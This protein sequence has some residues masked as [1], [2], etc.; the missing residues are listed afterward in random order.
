MQRAVQRF[1]EFE[2]LLDANPEVSKN[3]NN[4]LHL[5]IS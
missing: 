3:S 4:Q 1:E 2:A 5:Y